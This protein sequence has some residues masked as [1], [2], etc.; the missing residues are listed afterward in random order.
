LTI[1]FRCSNLHLEVYWVYIKRRQRRVSNFNVGHCSLFSSKESDNH[2]SQFSYG[3]NKNAAFRNKACQENRRENAIAIA[4]E[5]AMS[6]SV[7]Q[8]PVVRAYA[9]NLIKIRRNA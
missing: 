9:Q 4:A 6:D 5:P 3:R 1:I 8:R 7:H 2:C